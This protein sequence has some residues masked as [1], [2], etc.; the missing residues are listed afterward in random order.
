MDL[1]WI[2]ISSSKATSGASMAYME[3]GSTSQSLESSKPISKAWGLFQMMHQHQEHKPKGNLHLHEMA[4]SGKMERRRGRGGI[5]MR[6][7]SLFDG[8]FLGYNISDLTG[9]DLGKLYKLSAL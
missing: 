1:V 8:S 2:S 3:M 7:K 4:N 9:L 5:P 6:N